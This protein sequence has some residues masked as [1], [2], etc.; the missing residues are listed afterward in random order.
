MLALAGQWMRPFA[1]S[2]AA[3]AW[4]SDQGCAECPILSTSDW[5]T[6]RLAISLQRPFYSLA[7]MTE[8]RFSTNRR[9]CEGFSEDTAPARVAEWAR[10]TG[11]VIFLLP[12]SDRLSAETLAAYQDIGFT[13]T[14]RAFLT[15]S[16]MDRKLIIYFGQ[17]NGR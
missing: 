3:A 11:A 17:R 4:V 13:L 9:D 6:E 14:P 12:A 2:A 5:L 10:R 1:T 15:N 16:E 8:M 7:C